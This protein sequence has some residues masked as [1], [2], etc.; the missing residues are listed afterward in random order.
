M[1]VGSASSFMPMRSRLHRRRRPSAAR[2]ALPVSF[3][4]IEARMT[5]SC[6][7]VDRAGPACAWPRAGR[8]SWSSPSASASAPRRAALAA[9]AV[10]AVGQHRALRPA[11]AQPPVSRGLRAQLF[12]DQDRRHALGNGHQPLRP[13]GRAGAMS[14]TAAALAR[15]GISN[16]PA[17]T[18]SPTPSSRARHETSSA[19]PDRAG[20]LERVAA[21]RRA[22]DPPDR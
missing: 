7:R 4:T 16:S 18:G 8:A 21:T 6:L 5:A 3:S 1:T 9:L 19:V 11:A 15:A 13:A 12:L 2:T 17:W 14:S 22:L 20:L 10:I